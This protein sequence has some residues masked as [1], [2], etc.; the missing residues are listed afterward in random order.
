MFFYSV[1]GKKIQGKIIIMEKGVREYLILEDC[2]YLICGEMKKLG[3]RERIEVFICKKN[4][5]GRAFLFVGK[6][7]RWK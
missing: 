4:G 2:E 1:C 6:L 5:E 3:N 7:N